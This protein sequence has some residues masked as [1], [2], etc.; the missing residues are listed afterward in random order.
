M[1]DSFDSQQ[2]PLR[3][4]DVRYHQ[5]HLGTPLPVMASEF[6]TPMP[7]R[8]ALFCPPFKEGRDAGF[9]AFSPCDFSFF[10]GDD[11]L[12][13]RVRKDDGTYHTVRA[14]GDSEIGVDARERTIMLSDVSEMQSEDAYEYYLDRLPEPLQDFA[15]FYQ[16]LFYAVKEEAE[17]GYW[18]QIYLGGMIETH[19]DCTIMVKHPTNA[20]DSHPFVV[21]DG[22]V[23][24]G[25]WSG[26]MNIGIKPLVKNRWVDISK[27]TPL[28]QFVGYSNQIQNL[29]VIESENV[30][31]H[32]FKATLDWYFGEPNYR[33]KPGRYQRQ[34]SKKPER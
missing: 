29:D 11:F 1:A 7:R 15:Y 32:N 5:I 30:S 18:I 13:L 2:P 8:A 22:V 23:E 12:E 25:K 26:T 14:D 6:P 24:T 34:F 16:V 17:F 19:E 31:D 28:C 21:M 9:F 27:S 33:R 10:L 20:L 3:V 4:G